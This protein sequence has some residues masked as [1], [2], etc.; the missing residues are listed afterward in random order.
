MG[1]MQMQMQQPCN[2]C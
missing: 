2:A 1:M